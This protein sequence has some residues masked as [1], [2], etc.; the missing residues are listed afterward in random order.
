[1]TYSNGEYLEG[2][3]QLNKVASVGKSLEQ[4]L[5]FETY[6]L[7]FGDLFSGNLKTNFIYSVII[8]NE[9]EYLYYEQGCSSSNVGPYCIINKNYYTYGE[10]ITTTTS[11]DYDLLNPAIYTQG[12][13]Y[14]GEESPSWLCVKASFLAGNFGQLISCLNP[15][16]NNMTEIGINIDQ[17]N[18]NTSW[19]NANQT[20][21]QLFYNYLQNATINTTQTGT[22]YVGYSYLHSP[23]YQSQPN[24]LT[25]AT[26]NYIAN[27]SQYLYLKKAYQYLVLDGCDYN[28]C[29]NTILYP[30]NKTLTGF[31]NYQVANRTSFLF[32]MQPDLILNNKTINPQNQ[33]TFS[34][35]NVSKTFTLGKYFYV[36]YVQGN[37]IE[38]EEMNNTIPIIEIIDNESFYNQLYNIPSVNIT[39]ASSTYTE[40]NM[41]I[42]FPYRQMTLK[43]LNEQLN[44]IFDICLI[45]II[46][47]ILYFLGVIKDI[48]L[49]IK[50]IIENL[51]SK[52]F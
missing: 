1:S 14:A 35:K 41:T 7:V 20:D 50:G 22:Y 51:K 5:G 39:F 28:F 9:K 15:I 30:T 31:Y 6:K 40:P 8:N 12:S 16:K 26:N 32:E 13:Y 49:K 33:I 23:T 10:N 18:F 34:V 43:F 47:G 19:G 27:A 52:Y 25:T 36:N 44:I 11:T 46:I 24:S 29:F 37:S 17:L 2:L 21:K 3:Q 45:I 4:S 42:I 48:E 38:I